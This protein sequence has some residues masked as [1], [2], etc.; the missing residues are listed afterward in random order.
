MPVEDVRAFYE[1]VAEDKDLQEKLKALDKEAKTAMDTAVGELI[2]I[3][4]AAGFVFTPQDLFEARSEEPTAEQRAE[5]VR[6]VLFPCAY[7]YYVPPDP[8]CAHGAY[9]HHGCGANSAD[10]IC[11][12]PPS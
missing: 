4:K 7:L 5:Q 12:Q 10:L 2:E 6:D 11:S 1:K 9:A 8:P 3:A